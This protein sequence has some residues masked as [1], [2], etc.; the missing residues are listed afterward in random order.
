MT[1]IRTSLQSCQPYTPM[2]DDDL[3]RQAARLYH[4]TG[5]VMIR[6]EWIRNDLDRQH[7]QNMAE[8]MFGK[9]RVK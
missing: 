1:H 8:K 3:R 9:R 7:M 5:T 2:N 6:P 4:Q